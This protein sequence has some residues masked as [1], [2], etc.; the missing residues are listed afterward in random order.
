MVNGKGG[1]GKSTCSL[2]VAAALQDNGFDVVIEDRDPQ[3]SASALAPNMG[4]RIGSEAA[5]VIIDTPPNIR[6]EGMLDAI[7][8]S[9]LV[10]LI[11]SPS[12]SDFSTTATTAELIQK[13]RTGKTLILFNKVK[14]NTTFTKELENTAGLLP[15]DRLKNTLADR[16]N[17]QKAQ[18]HGWKA[19]SRLEQNEMLKVALEIMA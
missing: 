2:L 15:F 5:F 8:A 6:D 1:V 11:S 9:D 13:E 4:L 3:R 18:L 14:S 16:Q 7:R 10:V 17:Y 19:L 12:P